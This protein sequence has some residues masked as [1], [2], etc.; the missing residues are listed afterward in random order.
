MFSGGEHNVRRF[1]IA[2]DD[3]RLVRVQVIKHLTKL[4]TDI[5]DL[6]RREFIAGRFLEAFTQSLSLDEIH[7]Q[8]PAIH[9]HE[10]VINHG[11]AGILQ[12]IKHK[13]FISKSFAVSIKFLLSQTALPHFLDSY[14]SISIK[15]I[16]RLIDRSHTAR[17]G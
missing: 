9:F 7:H 2:K 14:V 12:M 5:D 4:D 3:R 17:T 16:L 1:E 10:M 6:L 11:E 15:R 13:R 8:V